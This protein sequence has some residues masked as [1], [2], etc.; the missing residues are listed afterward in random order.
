MACK[1]TRLISI[2]QSWTLEQ[3][4]TWKTDILCFL[5]LCP[6]I[7]VSLSLFLCVCVCCDVCVSLCVCVVWILTIELNLQAFHR[8][9][10]HVSTDYILS[11]NFAIHLFCLVY[12]PKHLS[13]Q[14]T[15]STWCRIAQSGN[16]SFH[17]VVWVKEEAKKYQA[18]LTAS[19]TDFK[20]LI[21]SNVTE[22][23]LVYLV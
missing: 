11:T 19:V 13:S 2:G 3:K 12:E 8:P 9:E 21:N 20:S 23:V 22:Y 15:W 14:W 1:A 18:E 4:I 7:S 16:V 5:F 17:L 6:L 10:K